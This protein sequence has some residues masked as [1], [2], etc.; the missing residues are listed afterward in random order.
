MK[1]DV[2]FINYKKE[3]YNNQPV[4]YCKRC[5]SLNIRELNND[6]YCDQCGCT[7]ILEGSIEQWE[8]LNNK[9]YGEQQDKY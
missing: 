3:Y 8:E 1:N 7:E 5:L 9:K 2:G 6:D 4:L